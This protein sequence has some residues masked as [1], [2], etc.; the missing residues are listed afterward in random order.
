MIFLHHKNETVSSELLAEN[1]CTNP[2]R[3][4]RVM[5]KLR[6]AGI[7][8]TRQGRTEGGYS[9]PKIKQIT[10]SDIAEAL[11]TNFVDFTWRSGSKEK[12]CLISSGMSDYM[13]EMIQ[14]MNRRC[15]DYLSVITVADAEKQLTGRKDL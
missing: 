3:V 7:V 4:R 15:K 1:V 6:K 5:S 11:D 13:D 14:E 8:E 9:Y 2:G 12:K 10:L